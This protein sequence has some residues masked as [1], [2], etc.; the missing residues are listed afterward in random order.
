MYREVAR[1][2]V[3]TC[4]RTWEK[5]DSFAGYRGLLV[6]RVIDCTLSSVFKFLMNLK[7][8]GIDLEQKGIK[9]DQMKIFSRN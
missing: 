6:Q 8:R 7:T 9:D 2:S 3:G 4:V 1:C 5:V